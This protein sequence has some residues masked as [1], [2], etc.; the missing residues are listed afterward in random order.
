MNYGWGSIIPK[1]SNTVIG[2]CAR[3][4][5]LPLPV[6]S[7]VFSFFPFFRRVGVLVC[8]PPFSKGDSEGQEIPLM[9]CRVKFALF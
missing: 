8:L 7:D 1:N 9:A 2:P 5:G 3:T 6:R 4:L